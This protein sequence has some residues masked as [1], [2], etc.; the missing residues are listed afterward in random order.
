MLEV[1]EIKTFIDSITPKHWI[2]IVG[3]KEM[4]EFFNT[5]LREQSSDVQGA[6]YLQV[7][8]MDEKNYVD[9]GRLA[10][11]RGP[12][13]FF[14]G[15]ATCELWI[16]P[17]EGYEKR[18]ISWKGTLIHEIAHIAVNRLMAIKLKEQRRTGTLI[19][20]SVDLKENQHGPTFQKALI[21][22]L[23]RAYRVYG[24]DLEEVWFEIVNID[25]NIYFS[26]E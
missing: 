8:I 14:D 10:E 6:L 13:R 23:Q 21:R 2:P 17:H 24:D 9:S 3:Y 18:G 19:N 15:F 7:L 12:M 22:M 4:K 20:S 5:V 26:D 11:C 25:L 1:A 16:Y